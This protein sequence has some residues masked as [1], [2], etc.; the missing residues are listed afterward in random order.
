MIRGKILVTGAGGFNGRHLVELL[1]A[2]GYEVRATDLPAGERTSS[3]EF[4][5]DLQVEFVPSDLTDP[6]TL[7]DALADIDCV[8][9]L[10]SLFDYSAP[11]E[12]NREINVEGTRNLCEAARRAG[13]RKFIL[14]S[15][16]GVYGV[17]KEMPVTE[18]SPPN[19][20]NNYEISKLE[21][22]QTVLEYYRDGHFGVTV[23][24]P[25]PVYGAGNRYGFINLIKLITFPPRV[26][27]LTK[28]KSRIPSVNVRDV[29]GAGIFLL[30]APDEKTGGEVFNVIDDTNIPLQDFLHFVAGLAGKETRIIPF[31]V[32]VKLMLAMGHFGA[33][34]NR[35][36]SENFLHGRPLLED[37]TVDYLA[38]NYIYSNEKIK[39]LGYKFLYPDCRVGL[40]E[41]FDWIKEENLE[42]LK[43]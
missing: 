13:I 41:M 15:T 33:K 42:P 5:K 25:A 16:L 14:W 9:H 19:P 29:A 30:E 32:N 43:I 39:D 12:L 8:M 18:E 31:P 2:E 6:S 21:Q 36:V 22:E 3:P 17:Q 7:D 26:P 20:G 27:V 37:A 1:K 4:F 11:L 23:M 40:I 28:L 24:R 10:A 34:V 35:F 38:F